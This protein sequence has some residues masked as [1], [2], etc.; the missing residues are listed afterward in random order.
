MYAGALLSGIIGFFLAQQGLIGLSYPLA[1]RIPPDRQARFL[2]D[3]W[4]HT[5]SYGIGI[6]G[7]V[8]LAVNTFRRRNLL[9]GAA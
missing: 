3:A 4:A 9:G 8:I 7:G 2:A 5:A 6:V 1:E